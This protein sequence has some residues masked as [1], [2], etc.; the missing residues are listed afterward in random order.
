MIKVWLY[1]KY[2]E[3]VECVNA[4]QWTHNAEC[5]KKLESD[6]LNNSKKLLKW[7]HTCNKG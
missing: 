4:K 3:H 5:I 7:H 6:W 1:I 2:R